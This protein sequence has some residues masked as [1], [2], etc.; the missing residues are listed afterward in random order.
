MTNS[1]RPGQWASLLA[2]VKPRPDA[3]DLVPYF[4]CDR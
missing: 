1:I 2:L 4:R 3:D